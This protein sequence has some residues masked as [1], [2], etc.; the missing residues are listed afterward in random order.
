MIKEVCATIVSRPRWLKRNARVRARARAHS[1]QHMWWC[2]FRVLSEVKW[3][4]SQFCAEHSRRTPNVLT[5]CSNMSSNYCANVCG[6]QSVCALCGPAVCVWTSEWIECCRFIVNFHVL[7]LLRASL[8]LVL[9]CKRFYPCDEYHTHQMLPTSNV[10]LP[11]RLSHTALATTLAHHNK[12]TR[13][14]EKMK[15]AFSRSF[16]HSIC[17]KAEH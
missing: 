16:V 11:L 9:L 15:N 14:E 7:A 17:R 2:I 1:L 3:A 5:D 10:F 6:Q 13:E 4:I 8:F 12:W